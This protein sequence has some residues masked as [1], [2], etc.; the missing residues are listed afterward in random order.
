M[1]CHT[2]VD[3]DLRRTPGNSL[4]FSKKRTVSD[5][6]SMICVLIEVIAGMAAHSRRGSPFKESHLLWLGTFVR[7]E[8]LSSLSRQFWIS[9]VLTKSKHNNSL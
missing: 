3:G 6:L 8:Y 2:L 9:T 4:L 7:R 1:N 5:F